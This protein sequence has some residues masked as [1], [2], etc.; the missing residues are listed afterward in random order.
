MRYVRST[1]PDKSAHG[2]HGAAARSRSGEI[3]QGDARSRSATKQA[4]QWA[5]YFVEETKPVEEQPS[6]EAEEP[7]DL[8]P[9]NDSHA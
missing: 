1:C 9:K 7:L 5:Y 4:Y 6:A 2:A 8:T 3:R